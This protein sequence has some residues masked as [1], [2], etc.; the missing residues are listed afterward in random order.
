[1]HRKRKESNYIHQ[2]KAAVPRLQFT[3][4]QNQQN[5]LVPRAVFGENNTRRRRMYTT[6]WKCGLFERARRQGR[7]QFIEP[8]SV[9]DPIPKFTA[10]SVRGPLAVDLQRHFAFLFM[11]STI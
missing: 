4:P 8:L 3:I 1:M 10:H 7:H 11:V 2:N 5:R 6:T 9:L